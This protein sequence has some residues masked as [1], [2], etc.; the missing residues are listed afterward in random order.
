MNSSS[1]TEDVLRAVVQYK[2][3]DKVSHVD[4]RRAT[5]A[6]LQQHTKVW[7]G[8]NYELAEAPDDLF[9]SDHAFD[10]WLSAL[11]ALA[12]SLDRTITWRDS[13]IPEKHVDVEGHILI[14]SQD[15]DNSTSEDLK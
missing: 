3:K 9:T 15:K 7:L 4:Q 13:K 11:T 8:D 6:L 1:I 2:D 12:H 10:A 5:Y 14:L